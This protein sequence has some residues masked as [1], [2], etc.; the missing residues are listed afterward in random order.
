VAGAVGGDPAVCRR[1]R[2]GS[3]TL[4]RAREQGIDRFDNTQTTRHFDVI[5]VWESYVRTAGEDWTFIS[6]GDKHL[7]TKPKPVKEI[8]P[9]QH[10]ER[11]LALGYGSLE[12][13]R[14]FPMSNVESWQMLQQETNDI[15]NLTL[16]ALKQ[17]IMPVS[18]VVRG[19]N[20]DLDQLKRRGR[21]TSILVTKPEDVTWEKIPDMSQG[22]VA[23]NQKLD[24]EFDDLSAS[25]TTGRW[26][27]I[28]HLGGRWVPEARRRCRQ[29]GA[30]FDVR[31]WIETWCEV[32]AQIVRLE[33]YYEAIRSSSASAVPAPSCTRSSASTR[34]PTSSWR[35]T[36]RSRSM[37]ALAPVT[38]SSG[39]RSSSRRCR[40]RC[41]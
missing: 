32:L 33:Q 37:S 36:S 17:N 15:R 31:I 1:G 14:I 12:A 24:I 19:R 4:R 9:E 40:W 30:E 29:R 5:W 23:M 34:S 27:T 28:T 25:R 18:K 21:G 39:C 11:P 10:G 22:A 16:D 2:Q 13:F 3:G 41:R 20:V 35:T 7:L 8:Y 38:R 6:I 26:R